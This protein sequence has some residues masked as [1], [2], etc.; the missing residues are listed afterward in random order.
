MRGDVHK[1]FH[2]NMAHVGVIG[3][4]P[5]YDYAPCHQRKHEQ[6]RQ[7]DSSVIITLM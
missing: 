2:G 3:H 1:S 6:L 4:A 5:R 7:H